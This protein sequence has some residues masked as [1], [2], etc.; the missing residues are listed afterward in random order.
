MIRLIPSRIIGVVA[1]MGLVF[2]LSSLPASQ[3]ARL[4]WSIMMMNLAHVPLFA[5]LSWVTLWAVAGPLRMR[6]LSVLLGC[7]LFAAADEWYQSYVPGR[8]SSLGDVGADLI[9]IIIGIALRV[10]WST[11]VLVWKGE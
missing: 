9:G 1:Y 2:A 10:V 11:K 5:G 8:I 7:L 3:T 6:I 4:G